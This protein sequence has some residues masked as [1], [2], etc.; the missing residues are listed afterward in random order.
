MI[1]EIIKI[2]LIASVFSFLGE[3][4]MIFS[5][6]RKWIMKLPPWLN[7]PLGSCNLC[8]SG[9]VCF[10]YFIFTQPFNIINLLFFTSAGVFLSSIYSAIYYYDES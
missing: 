9:Q 1:Y 6:Y 4:D 2:S 7:K 5:F 8:I 10:W 3:P